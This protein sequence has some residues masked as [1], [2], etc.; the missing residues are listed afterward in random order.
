M[1]TVFHDLLFQYVLTELRK[2][3]ALFAEL[4]GESGEEKQGEQG[5]YPGD[6]CPPY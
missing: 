3:T 2:V 5:D 4:C 6:G 1:S